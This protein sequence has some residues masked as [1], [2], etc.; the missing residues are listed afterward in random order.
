V[1]EQTSTQIRLYNDTD[2]GGHSTVVEAEAISKH[3]RRR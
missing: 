3:G 2:V 1:S